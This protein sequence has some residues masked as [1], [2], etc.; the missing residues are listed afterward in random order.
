LGARDKE[1]TATEAEVRTRRKVQRPRLF[2]VLIHDDDFTT[3]DFVV[4]V[5]ET[6]FRHPRAEARRIM[7]DV[8]LRGIGLAGIFPH[9]IAETKAAKVMEAARSQEF[10]LLCTV[11]PEDT[12]KSSQ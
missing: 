10:P 6:I 7:L 3:M 1:H 2:R 4:E 11:E 9:E 5:L 8:H 12:D